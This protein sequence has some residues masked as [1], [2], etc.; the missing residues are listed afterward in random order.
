M[1][2]FQPDASP[3]AG[4]ITYKAPAFNFGE[5]QAVNGGFNFDLPLA[6]VQAFTNNAL[7]FSAN[8]SNNAQ[9][10]MQG[11]LNSAQSNVNSTADR[12]YSYQS[13]ALTS[14]QQLGNRQL[15]VLQYGIKRATKSGGFCFITTAVC[16]HMGLPDDCSEL[17]TLRNF[18]DT[19]MTKGVG[20]KARAK[21]VKEYYEVA[22]G[23]VDGLNKL[24]ENERA[25]VYHVLRYN[26]LTVCMCQI[27]QGDNEN[28]LVTYTSMVDFAKQ[29]AGL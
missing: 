22:P 16:E 29:K 4:G 26:F 13:Q 11:V 12:A 18:R 10:F 19:Y 27:S 1:A 23:I 15:D 3:V 24:P 25:H 8:N 6:T 28:A 20:A 9:G 5:M 14:M 2:I 17:Q 21:L 7:N